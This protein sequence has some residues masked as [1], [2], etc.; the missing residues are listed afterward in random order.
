[1]K[2][3]YMLVVEEKELTNT[4]MN[5]RHYARGGGGEVSFENLLSALK[6]KITEKH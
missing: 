3:P 6:K 2:I 1:M 4:T 5:V